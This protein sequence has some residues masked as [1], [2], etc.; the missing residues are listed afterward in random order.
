MIFDI[1]KF[2][3][4]D[5]EGIRTTVFFKG[6]PLECWWCHNPE[7]RSSQPQ[8]IYRAGRCIHCGACIEACPEDALARENGRIVADLSRC[9][10]R[11]RCAHACP[12]E[13]TAIVGKEMTVAEVMEAIRRDRIF[14][15]QSG[16]GVTFS[17]GEPGMQLDFL[18]ALLDACAAEGIHTAVDTCGH[19]PWEAMEQVVR[20]TN[21]LLFDLKVM[22]AELHARF[23]GVGNE[24]ILRNLE[25]LAQM[26][27][28]EGMPYDI[29]IRVPVVPGV[30][31]DDANFERL[32]TFLSR[33]PGERLPVDLLPY[34]KFGRSKYEA[35]GMPHRL[36][37]TEPPPDEQMQRFAAI[38]RSHCLPVTVRGVHDES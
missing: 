28:V 20:R 8:R 27:A 19:L 21:L 29:L 34:Q 37:G 16:G 17:G 6:C 1:M 36:A 18:C 24:Q 11:G 33:L 12:T 31:D 30:N 10:L 13:A 9:D 25:L 15:D 26:R 2:A 22:D 5:G 14:Y 35:L 38:L 7:S 4:H 3:I 32:A 23:A